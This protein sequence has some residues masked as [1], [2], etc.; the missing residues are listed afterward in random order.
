[1]TR[2]KLNPARVMIVDD[3]PL[4]RKGLSALITDEADLEV[5]GQAESAEEALSMLKECKPDLMVIDIS[6]PGINGVDLIKRI[7]ARDRNVRLLVSSMHDESLFAERCLRAGANGFINK[8]CATNEVLCAIRKVL[9]GQIFLSAEMTSRMLHGA[10]SGQSGE[11]SSLETLSDRELEVFALIGKGLPIRDIADRLHL[12]VKTI[13]T[14]RDHIRR[15]LNINSSTE[16]MRHAVQW[17]LE[18]G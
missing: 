18:N 3:H 16:L 6:L 11:Q 12:S 7:R 15:K 2:S 10:I 1:M 13:E 5:C 4:V 17:V 9:D 14:H 8:E